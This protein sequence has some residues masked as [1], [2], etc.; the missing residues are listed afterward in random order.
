[1]DDGRWT[2]F[3]TFI[4]HLN[5]HTILSRDVKLL[6]S[7]NSCPPPSPPPSKNII[8]L[9]W[10]NYHEVL[11]A[12][13]LSRNVTH[14]FISLSQSTYT[15]INFPHNLLLLSRDVT[16]EFWNIEQQKFM[17]SP[18]PSK[19][20]TLKEWANYHELLIADF[21][22]RNVTHSFISLG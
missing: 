4:C 20:L 14:S 8:Y 7:E 1:M 19:N 18:S 5:C 10:T 22:S 6:N 17:P 2:I 3:L 15:C 13:F 21:S 11:I 12:D 9:D 16:M